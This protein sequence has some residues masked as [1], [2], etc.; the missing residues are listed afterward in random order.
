MK[1]LPLCKK[2][3]PD[4]RQLEAYVPIWPFRATVCEACG[5]AATDW[6]TFTAALWSLAIGW[7]WNG[8]VRVRLLPEDD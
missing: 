5:E 6:G 2:F 3:H 1:Q 8:I 4:A 7:W